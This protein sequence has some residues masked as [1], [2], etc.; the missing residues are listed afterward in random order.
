[1]EEQTI[2]SKSIKQNQWATMQKTTNII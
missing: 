2:H 1:V